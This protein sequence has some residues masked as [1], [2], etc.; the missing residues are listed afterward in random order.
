MLKRTDSSIDRNGSNRGCCENPA[1]SRDRAALATLSAWN[2]DDAQAQQSCQRCSVRIIIALQSILDI[3][4]FL[5]QCTL[6]FP[7]MLVL[8][9]CPRGN[10]RDFL[11]KV[12]RSIASYDHHPTHPGTCHRRKFAELVTKD[13]NQFRTSSR[14]RNGK[15]TQARYRARQS[16]CVW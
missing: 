8:E 1:A 2:F 7:P 5:G 6:S 11:R 10:L 9:F 13:A 15:L 14:V 16:G 12:F 3:I 4:S